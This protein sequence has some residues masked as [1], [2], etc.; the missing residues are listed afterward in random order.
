[1]SD[2]KL[3]DSRNTWRLSKH[4][5]A[6]AVFMMTP[7]ALAAQSTLY[8]EPQKTVAGQEISYTAYKA[9]IASPGTSF[10]VQDGGYALL[11]AG[12]RIE[13]HHGFKVVDN[14]KVTIIVENAKSIED[15]GA[16]SLFSVFPVP[17]GES[18]NI[19]SPLIIDMIRLTDIN[20]F[21]VIDQQKSGRADI[22]LDLSIVNP[23]FYI[24][25]IVAGSVSEK[26][27]IEKN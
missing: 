23:G 2:N 17:A 1:M 4:V 26:I 24:L 7:L 5:L 19:T 15:T 14:G 12:S 10:I 20:G 22:G 3:S 6:V 18:I 16:K 13:L 8:L 27:R 21:T 11:K 25:E 9:I